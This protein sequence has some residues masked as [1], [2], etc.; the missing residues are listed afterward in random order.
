MAEDETTQTPAP[1]ET[2][3]ETQTPAPPKTQRE[4]MEEVIK[5]GRGVLHKGR[6][7]TQIE[8][9]PTEEQLS[10]STSQQARSR[11]ERLDIEIEV[12]QRERDR[13]EIDER[14]AVPSASGTRSKAQDR[15][16]RQDPI[17]PQETVPVTDSD[18]LA[19][20]QPKAKA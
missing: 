1:P 11:R 16:D 7:I 13:L 5:S 8:D 20:E 14:P 3:R 12:L 17:K 6:I 2:Q 15:Q 18:P 9:L 19:V 4:E 10:A